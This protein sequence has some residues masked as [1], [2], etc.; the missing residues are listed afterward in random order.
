MSESTTP[1]ELVFDAINQLRTVLN[2]ADFCDNCGL[3]GEFSEFRNAWQTFHK[4]LLDSA[5]LMRAPKRGE[6]LWSVWL[7]QV[8]LRAAKVEK[9]IETRGYDTYSTSVYDLADLEWIVRHGWETH[10]LVNKWS[11]GQSKTLES[12]LE[13]SVKPLEKLRQLADEWFEEFKQAPS[14]PTGVASRAEQ[15]N[16]LP[17]SRKRDNFIVQASAILL[18]VVASAEIHSQWIE[19]NDFGAKVLDSLDYPGFLIR[20]YLEEET[21]VGLGRL[22]EEL[23][24][25]VVPDPV[26]REL[27]DPLPPYDNPE[28]Y[29]RDKWIYEN[30]PLYTCQSLSVEL[31]KLE[32]AKG[33]SFIKSPNAIKAAAKKF[34]LYHNLPIRDFSG[35]RADK[36]S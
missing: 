35:P 6:G 30:M 12:L 16:W 29:A 14:E 2:V 24:P 17:W 26:V 15:Q 1:T 21:G 3:K 27:T 7:R 25:Q 20:P 5:E 33:W 9:F 34:A 4:A 19:D 31:K 11:R 23:S 18:E 8:W 10:Y 32:K 28:N 22:A 36:R 13:K